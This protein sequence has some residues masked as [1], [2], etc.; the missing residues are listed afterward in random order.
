MKPPEVPCAMALRSAGL[1]RGE[2][3]AK[4]RK[5][6]RAKHARGLFRDHARVV[7]SPQHPT[8]PVHRHRHHGVRARNQ[9]CVDRVERLKPELAAEMH[10]HVPPGAAL[11]GG[12]PARERRRV[13]TETDRPAHAHPSCVKHPRAAFTAPRPRALVRGAR[14]AAPP[15]VVGQRVAPPLRIGD[16]RGDRRHAAAEHPVVEPVEKARPSGDAL[17]APRLAPLATQRPHRARKRPRIH[18]LRTSCHVSPIPAFDAAPQRYR[19]NAGIL[20]SP[21]FRAGKRSEAPRGAS[22]NLLQ[23]ASQPRIILRSTVFRMPPLR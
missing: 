23:D 17:A 10:A 1:P 22:R 8:R 19:R 21:H 11:D 9:A 4:H 12:H 13:A 15:A 7:D 18:R 14:A 2:A 3:G 6:W 16:H 20:A 5:V